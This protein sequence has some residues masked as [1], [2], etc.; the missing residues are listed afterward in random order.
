[1][2]QEEMVFTHFNRAV[3]NTLYYEMPGIEIKKSGFTVVDDILS[4]VSFNPGK[5]KIRYSRDFISACPEKESFSFRNS[6]YYRDDEDR[7]KKTFGNP[8][9][10][11][12]YHSDLTHAFCLSAKTNDSKLVSVTLL[13]FTNTEAAVLDS[14]KEAIEVVAKEYSASIKHKHTVGM[15]IQRGSAISIDD[16]EIDSTR[17]PESK[18]LNYN[19]DFVEFSDAIE[20]RLTGDDRSGLVILHGDPGSGKTSY[21]RYLMKNITNKKLIYI[22]PSMAASLAHPDLLKL[23]LLHVGSV[24]IIEDA[25][26]VVMDRESGIG[27]NQAVSNLLNM[28]DGILSDALRMQII[29]TFNTD[30]SNIDQALLRPGRLI[31]KYEFKALTKEKTKRLIDQLYGDGTYEREYEGQKM[32]LAQIYSL[33]KPRFCEEK[34]KNAIGFV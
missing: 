15:I 6:F 14:I 32:T 2:E 19:D 27:N 11:V 9:D 23:M 18:D 21:I 25:E 24:L 17:I 20:E 12:A 10:S 7:I 1:M 16:I 22:P 3:N 5:R 28:T 33:N 4:R 29:C 30:I 31:G 34:V 8:Y 26:L 13:H